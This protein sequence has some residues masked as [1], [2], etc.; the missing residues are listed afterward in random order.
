[1]KFAMC[2]VV[3]AVV[4]GIVVTHSTGPPPSGPPPSGLLLRQERNAGFGGA[5]PSGP[6]P[7]GPPP[8]GIPPFGFSPPSN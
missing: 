4:A 3:F 6:P 7:S 1:M 8:S 2:A 5:P